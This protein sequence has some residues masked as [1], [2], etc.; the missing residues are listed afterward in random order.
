M[1]ETLGEKRRRFT[2]DL[3][4]LITYMNT[5]A[6]ETQLEEVV[7]RQTIAEE[8]AAKGTGIVHSL[9]LVG[10]AADVSLFV[11]GEYQEGGAA[12]LQ[13]G[14]F[15]ESLGTDHRWGGRFTHPDED[16][17]SIEHEGIR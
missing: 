11:Q 14:L 3:A 13:A 9:H 4:T 16:H 7:R 17:F 2:K 5:N 10:L 15:W 8:D 12:Y 6:Y 1:A